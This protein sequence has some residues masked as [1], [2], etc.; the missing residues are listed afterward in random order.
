MSRD[1]I[2]Q[3]LLAHLKA[4]P[5]VQQVLGGRIYALVLPANLTTFPAAT[6]SRVSAVRSHAKT[7]PVGLV[8][9]RFQ[10]SVWDP[11]LLNA[12]AGTDAVRA[13]LD[14][15]RGVMGDVVIHSIRSDV[16]VDLYEEEV[17]RYQVATDYI[18]SHEE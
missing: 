7:G 11:Q 18:V 15:F 14:G 17:G 13:A 4:D 12:M 8:E 9:S 2:R 6:L 1:R 10:V 16:Q 5:G 3:A